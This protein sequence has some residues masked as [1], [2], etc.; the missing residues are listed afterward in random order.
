MYKNYLLP[1]CRF[2]LTVHDITKTN[3]LALDSIV[4]R[5]LKNWIGLPRSATPG[6][7]HI[8]HLTDIKSIRQ[9]YLEAHSAA[10]MSSRLKGDEYVNNAL[11]SK[12]DRESEWVRKFSI[13]CYAESKF[14]VCNESAITSSHKKKKVELIKSIKDEINETWINHLKDLVVQGNMLRVSILEKAD[15]IWK[16]F[17]F[18]MPKGVMKFMVNSFLDTLPTKNNLSRWGKKMTTNCN[19]CSKKETLHH[20]LNHCQVMLEQGRYTWRHNSVLRIIHDTLRE[21]ADPSWVFYC[22]LTGTTKVA[23]TTIP[24]DILATQQRPDLVLINRVS[25]KII[26]IELTIPFEQ[27]IRNAH[28]RKVNKYSSLIMDLEEQSYD[29]K[30]FCIEI[31]SRGLI[32]DDNKCNIETIFTSISVG[33]KPH[34]N[35]C[36]KFQANLSKRAILASYSIFYSKYDHDWSIS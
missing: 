14:Q 34:K 27:N 20:V 10:Y 29:A 8:P 9:V 3:L 18:N 33:N 32:S 12:L 15:Y 4:H 23:G 7:L 31:G 6:I 19:L 25:K 21:I 13:T 36:K 2:L 11:D 24:P 1:S 17:I 16:S 35:M 22:D 28:D 26:I 5:Y 30:L